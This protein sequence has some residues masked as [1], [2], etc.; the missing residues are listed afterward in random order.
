MEMASTGG[1]GIVIML[2]ILAVF[3]FVLTRK[4]N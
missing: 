2:I 1:G 4:K 3:A